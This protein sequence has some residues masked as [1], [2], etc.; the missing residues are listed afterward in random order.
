METKSTEVGMSPGLGADIVRC[1]GSLKLPATRM[2]HFPEAYMDEVPGSQI[3]MVESA[4]AE[5][6]RLLEEW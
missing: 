4:E 3:L 1:R 2:S 6:M 5:T